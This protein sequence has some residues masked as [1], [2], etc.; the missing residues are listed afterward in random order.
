[1]KLE[2]FFAGDGDCLL[3]TSSDGHRAL[4]D[5]G[6]SE[7]FQ[8][9]TWPALQALEKADKAIDL[10][11]V[12]HIDA[13]HISGILWLMKAVAAWSVYDYQTTEGTTQASPSPPCPD[14]PRSSASGTTHGGRSS[15]ISQARSR[16]T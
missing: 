4:I 13:D 14:H 12:S 9:Q 1:M 2:V 15:A 11:V 10:V 7:T 16:P 8:K 6:R 5:G 3:L